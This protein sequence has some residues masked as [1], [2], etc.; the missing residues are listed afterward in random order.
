M[1]QACQAGASPQHPQR[2]V[3]SAWHLR[4]IWP[5]HT[6]SNPYATQRWRAYPPL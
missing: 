4:H 2:G 5:W 6:Y 1:K 3:T